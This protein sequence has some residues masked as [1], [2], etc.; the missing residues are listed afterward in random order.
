ML[1]ATQRQLKIRLRVERVREGAARQV[2]AQIQVPG[3]RFARVPEPMMVRDGSAADGQSIGGSDG[4]SNNS[5]R[6]PHDGARRCPKP[7]RASAAR[8]ALLERRDT[9]LLCVYARNE[10]RQNP[11]R[12]SYTE[13]AIRCQ[14]V[15]LRAPES[16]WARAS[17]SRTAGSRRF[18]RA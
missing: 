6:D 17:A 7:S 8:G 3:I 13:T 11:C 18:F 4:R 5:H 14:R 9:E 12:L 1:V 2:V 15:A 16:G 10:G